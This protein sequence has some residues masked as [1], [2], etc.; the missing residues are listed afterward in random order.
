MTENTRSVDAV[1]SDLQRA[2]VRAVRTFAAEVDR[3][4]HVRHP[5]SLTCHLE[6]A[7]QTIVPARLIDLSEGGA[8]LA[9]VAAIPDGTVGF[10]RIEGIPTVLR[11][12]AVGTSQGN[13]RLAFEIDAAT[14]QQIRAVLPL[15]EMEEAA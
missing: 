5:L 3:R 14:R 13:L 7:G 4:A 9:G 12:R 6:V 11:S 10:L 8:Q 2:I 15:P 1:T